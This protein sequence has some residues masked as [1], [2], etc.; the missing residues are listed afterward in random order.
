MLFCPA[1]PVLDGIVN[2]RLYRQRRKLEVLGSDLVSYLDLVSEAKLFHIEMVFDLLLFPGKGHRVG[3]VDGIQGSP[4]QIREDGDRALGALRVLLTEHVNGTQTV[5]EEVRLQ[6]GR[7]NIQAVFLHGGKHLP[8]GNPLI[9]LNTDEGEHQ[10]QAGHGGQEQVL[11]P[12]ELQQPAEHRHH[13]QE[14]EQHR[15][16]FS[17]TPCILKQ[18]ADIDRDHQDDPELRTPLPDVIQQHHEYVV[19][20]KP[21]QPDQDV[22]AADRNADPQADRVSPHPVNADDKAKQPDIDG[23]EN[24]DHINQHH[25]HGLEKTERTGRKSVLPES[26]QRAAAHQ[27]EPGGK[28]GGIASL[29]GFPEAGSRHIPGGDQSDDYRGVQAEGTVN[30]RF[31]ARCSLLQSVRRTGLPPTH[32]V[33]C[34]LRGRR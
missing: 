22:E 10:G 32:T 33:S 26:G 16:I 13:R 14:A 6:L 4:Q 9:P 15:I 24:H 7:R 27:K 2:Q 30:D 29:D 11:R 3:T 20:E 8:H 5:I 21:D 25:I 19:T 28:H 17:E 34:T 23:I 31:Q 18:E 1:D 12:D